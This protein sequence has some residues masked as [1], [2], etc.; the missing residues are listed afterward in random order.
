V[1]ALATDW[2]HATGVYEEHNAAVRD[3][4]PADRLL[5]IAP[6][7]GWGPLCGFLGVAEPTEPY[8][9]LNDPAQ[10]WARVEARIGEARR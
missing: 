1:S 8:P 2:E 9:H 3:A 10:F 6:G 4:I 5:T 7:A